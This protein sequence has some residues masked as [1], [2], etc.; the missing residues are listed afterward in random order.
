MTNGRHLPVSLIPLGTSRRHVSTG[1]YFTSPVA[2]LG[3]ILFLDPLLI[4]PGPMK[5]TPS[6]KASD[7]LKP[8]YRCPGNPESTTDQSSSSN[9]TPGPSTSRGR[10]R[11]RSSRDWSIPPERDTDWAMSS[12]SESDP[13]GS[14]STSRRVYTRSHA[15]Q[16]THLDSPATGAEPDDTSAGGA[17][18]SAAG[19]SSDPNADRP[20]CLDNSCPGSL[21]PI[22]SVPCAVRDL[23]GPLI[24]MN[25]G[26]NMLA[27][28]K[29]CLLYTSPSPRD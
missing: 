12:A 24:L 20:P 25:N 16:H 1:H 14:P 17:D 22:C 28:S 7:F 15:C 6:Y 9:T 8:E 13:D 26:N 4:M 11:G 3:F 19:S 18:V 2:P 10:R 21:G 23:S 29:I 27:C 5:R